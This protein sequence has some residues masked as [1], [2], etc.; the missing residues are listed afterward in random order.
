M[1]LW[2][3]SEIYFGLHPAR[4]WHSTAKLALNWLYTASCFS[5]MQM[6][7]VYLGASVHHKICQHDFKFLWALPSWL[8]SW[9]QVHS[10]AVHAQQVEQTL[11]DWCKIIST[12]FILSLH[13]I[14]NQVEFNLS[15]C[16]P[17]HPATA[18]TYTMYKQ[19][20]TLLHC[21]LCTRLSWEY[22]STERRLHLSV[23]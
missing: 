22:A 3:Q 21:S 1:T 5:R 9:C 20:R 17:M 23:Q 6:L 16:M 10:R 4:E 7:L 15:P 14:L 11:F 13:Y 8:K 12:N 18:K 19:W 2:V